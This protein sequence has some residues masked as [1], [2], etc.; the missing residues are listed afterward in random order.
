MTKFTELRDYATAVGATIDL[1]TPCK[2]WWGCTAGNGYGSVQTPTKQTNAHRVAYVLAHGLTLD[3]IEGRQVDH[4]CVNRACVNPQHLELITMQENRRRQIT[5]GYE[6]TDQRNKER[7]RPHMQRQRAKRRAVGE[8]MTQ[9]E[10]DAVWDSMHPSGTRSCPGC[11]KERSR[12]EYGKSKD[13]PGY[14][15]GWCRKCRSHYT[16]HK[17]TLRDCTPACV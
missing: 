6:P 2:V 16:M 5:N 7:Q 3:D 10:R 11:L 14:R 1:S 13:Q 9:A 15:S 12:D 4:L 17:H 8:A